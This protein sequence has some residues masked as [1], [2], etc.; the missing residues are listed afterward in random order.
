MPALVRG[1]SRMPSS[2][3]APGK[4]WPLVV[5]CL[6]GSQEVGLTG[7][8]QE[9]VADPEHA[10]ES[11]TGRLILDSHLAWTPEFEVRFADGAQ[12]RGSA[13][14]GET[15]SIFE[16]AVVAAGPSVFSEA[17]ARFAGR[18]FD[19]A[20]FDAATGE[21]AQGWGRAVA[22]ALSIGFYLAA[23]SKSESSTRAR[24]QPRLLLNVLNGGLHAYTNPVTSDIPEF[25]LYSHADD[26]PSVVDAYIGLLAA[27]RERLRLLPTAEVGGNTV[28]A[29]GEAPNEAALALL[30]DLLRSEGLEAMFGI[31]VDASADDWWTPDGYL[32]PVSGRRFGQG[33]IGDWWLSLIDRFG[34]EF[35]E[36]PLGERDRAGWHDLHDRR[37]SSCRLLAD[38]YTSTDIDQ[39]IGESKV[40]DVDG[41]LVKPNQ[42]GTIAGS[43]AFA[44]AARA[45]GLVVVAS[46]RSVETESTFLVHLA[47]D[48][49][50]DALKI[51][52]F[53][54]FAAVVKFNELLRTA[55]DA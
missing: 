26:L 43:L 25:L 44:A 23:R 6:G 27:A 1:R 46:H 7:P 31:A 12:G 2:K 45:A 32:M 54:D 21:L 16:E 28:H 5:G 18:K 53:R 22:L 17:A 14:R 3:A 15:V 37:P 30:R 4:P 29:L 48:M 38:N 8:D 20:S 40:G 19:Q 52:P 42:N 50:A 13:P 24:T 47:R 39:L 35:V 49:A 51:G 55:A 11:V 9:L 36:D 10:I 41:V 34:L 33:E